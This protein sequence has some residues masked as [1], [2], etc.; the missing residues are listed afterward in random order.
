MI[1]TLL[2]WL[3]SIEFQ[4]INPLLWYCLSHGLC[5]WPWILKNDRCAVQHSPSFSWQNCGNCRHVDLWS[6]R[7]IHARC[8]M[9]MSC[10]VTPIGGYRI[11]HIPRGREWLKKNDSS[12][13]FHELA[14]V[15]TVFSPP[16]HQ[17]KTGTPCRK[18]LKHYPTKQRDNI[19]IYYII[20]FSMLQLSAIPVTK[21]QK[22]TPEFLLVADFTAKAPK[23]SG[24]HEG[25]EESWEDSMD[26]SGSC[27]GW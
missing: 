18:I 10:I 3:Y 6:H 20:C 17:R 19:Y 12:V 4:L 1:A 25:V 15:K 27:K 23:G 26:F 24:D 22:H 2:V 16:R 9:L 8:S 7:G 13:N 11:P 14:F 5:Q 21:K